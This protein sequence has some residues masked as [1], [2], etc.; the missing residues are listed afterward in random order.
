MLRL[1]GSFL[2]VLL[3]LTSIA[4]CAPPPSDA[5]AADPAEDSAALQALL[6]EFL[7]NADK[8]WAHERFWAEDLVYTSSDGSRRGKPE[9]MAGYQDTDPQ[10]APEGDETPAAGPT[11]SGD[12]VDIRVYDDAA[13]VAFRLVIQPPEASGESTSYNFNTGTFLKREGEWRAVA[14]QSTRIPR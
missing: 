1:S 10:P 14:W 3:V 7:A 13:V 11:Y 4:A 9:I 5:P 2:T 8:G 12:Q 6:D